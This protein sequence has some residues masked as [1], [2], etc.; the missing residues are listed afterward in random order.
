MI[1]ATNQVKDRVKP[2]F[3]TRQRVL[4]QLTRIQDMDPISRSIRGFFDLNYN[5]DYLLSTSSRLGAIVKESMDIYEVMQGL[6][7]DSIEELDR[8][9]SIDTM[10]PKLR[11]EQASEMVKGS[12]MQV[13]RAMDNLG[14]T[15]EG[16]QTNRK[17]SAHKN[18]RE[19]ISLVDSMARLSLDF[20]GRPSRTTG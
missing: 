1:A 4:D 15:M 13:Q 9:H 19:M 14:I 2:I 17:S 18:W 8:L 16:V 7:G 6:H 3:E 20:W 10:M 11:E 5:Q 12:M